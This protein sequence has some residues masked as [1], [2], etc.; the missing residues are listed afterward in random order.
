MRRIKVEGRDAVY[1]GMSRVVGRQYLL[2]ALEKDVFVRMLWK[3]AAFCGVEVLTYCVMSNHF[4]LLLRIPHVQEVCDEEM[5]QRVE[6]LYG[7]AHFLPRA[8]R[9]HWGRHGRLPERERSALRA[10][11]GD[12]SFFMKELKQRFSRWYNHRHQREGALWSQRYR[13]VL[14]EDKPGCLRTLAAYIDLN[15][16]RAGLVP[17]PRSYR[18]CGYALACAGDKKARSGLLHALGTASWKEGAAEYR[19]Y[20]FQ[21]GSSPTK[22]GQAAIREETLRQVHETG[23]RISLAQSL[24]LRI[25]HV[26][27][28]CILGSR[29]FVEDRFREFRDRFG[30]RRT[31]GARPLRLL[32][33]QGICSARDLQVRALE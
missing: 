32:P 33:W 23:G 5:L 21:R 30:P 15:P 29:E 14:L 4:H 3:Q 2:G 25:R 7:R 28:G 12:I 10:R 22:Q 18:W 16:L 19:L 26:T 13:S 20:L 1:H 31:S 9:E 17:D 27:D 8:L 24:R 6:A 11:M